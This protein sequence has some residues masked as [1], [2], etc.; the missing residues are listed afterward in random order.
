MTKMVQIVEEMSARLSQI[1]DA[2]AALVRA[3]GEALSRVDH[4]LLQDVRSITTEHEAR[5]GAILHELQSLAT[6]IGAFP[7]IRDSSQSIPYTEQA[8]GIAYTEPAPEPRY[9]EPQ[10]AQPQYAQPP[11]AEP[12]HGAGYGEPAGRPFAAANGNH[13]PFA[14]SG[15]WREAT[16]NIEDELDTFFKERAVG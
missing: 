12:A 10:Y 14:R 1:A 15:D 7:A 16:S 11:Y 5:R 8:P 3:L 13:M 2:E 4:K 6:R 9:A